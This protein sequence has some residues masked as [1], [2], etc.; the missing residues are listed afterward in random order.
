MK[1]IAVSRDLESMGLEPGT[2][3]RIEGLPGEWTV[4]DRMAKRWRRRIDVYMGL[5][6][7][8]A[9]QFGRR[10]VKLRWAAAGE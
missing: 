10:T 7:D 5:D 6:V 9:R 2:R 1:I 8:G 4:A 3:V